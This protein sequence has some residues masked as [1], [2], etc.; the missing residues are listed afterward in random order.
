MPQTNQAEPAGPAPAPA[1]APGEVMT[2]DPTH[3]AFVEDA[4]VGGGAP[5]AI[6]AAFAHYTDDAHASVAARPAPTAKRRSAPKPAAKPEKQRADWQKVVDTTD[7]KPDSYDIGWMKDVDPRVLK[8]IDGAY[9]D[10]AFGPQAATAIAKDPELAKIKRER[11]KAIADVR[12]ANKTT[13]K[14]GAKDAPLDVVAD[15][16]DVA[17]DIQQQAR[18]QAIRAKLEAT[19]RKS[20]A[21]Q[22]VSVPEQGNVR[23]ADMQTLKRINYVSDVNTLSKD[24]AKTRKH[25]ESMR[26]AKGTD[27]A[28]RRV[29]ASSGI[30]AR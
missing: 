3:D 13:P 6:Y 26:A 9:S 20:A 7:G 18:E 30:P 17:Y 19:A 11:E 8:S 2:T 23:R 12:K 16:V 4:S 22:T 10:D 24:P 28:R 14:K 27:T 25:L 15:A 1:S 29:A 5:D 21:K